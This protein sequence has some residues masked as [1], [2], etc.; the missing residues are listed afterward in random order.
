MSIFNTTTS[1][2]L[3]DWT[4]TH[5][6]AIIGIIVVAFV[7][8]YIAARFLEKLIRRAIKRGSHG[9]LESEKKR[10]DTVIAILNGVLLIALWTIVLLTVV[11][12]FGVQI[13]PIL[14]AAGIAG[15]ALGFGAQYLIKDI[16]AGFFIIVENQ[17][18]VGDVVSMDGTSGLVEE[19]TLRMT[20]L[21]DLDGVVHHIPNGNPKVI[22]NLTKDMSRVNLDIRIGYDTE[23]EKAIKLIDKVGQDLAADEQW[24]DDITEAPH[25]LRVD[26]FAESALVLKILGET[27]PSRQWDVTGE[28]RKRL[29]IAFDKHGISMPYPQRVIHQSRK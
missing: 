20:T 11:A 14:A 8:R 5:G 26:D 16:I 19:I 4:L 29:K 6:I 24:K 18:R 27:L 13:G 12:E 23:L 1:Q 7:I 28:L 15:V 25:V 9:T 3:S 17:F 22:S 21:R 10:E 2:A